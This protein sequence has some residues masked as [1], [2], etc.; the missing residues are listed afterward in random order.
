MNCWCGE[1]AVDSRTVNIPAL[2]VVTLGSGTGTGLDA[3]IT[4]TVSTAPTSGTRGANG[5]LTMPRTSTVPG[6]VVGS[7]SPMQPNGGP[8]LVG[9]VQPPRART[10][11]SARARINTF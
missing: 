9:N 2:S 8:G 3:V 5:S 4:N 7:W 6:A 1:P 11:A 10:T